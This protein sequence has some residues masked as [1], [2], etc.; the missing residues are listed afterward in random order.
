MRSIEVEALSKHYGSTVA[1]DG[2]SF[3]VEPGEVVG[4]LGPNGAG[5]TTTM[6]ILAG[7]I[8]PSSGAARIGGLDVVEESLEVR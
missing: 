6:K 7:F 1:I 5:K 4:F 2:I 3:A 8:A